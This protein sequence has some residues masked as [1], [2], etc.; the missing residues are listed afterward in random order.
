VN[1]KTLKEL[2]CVIG[3]KSDF[4]LKQFKNFILCIGGQTC[5][6]LSSVEAYDVHSKTWERISSLNNGNVKPIVA[7]HGSYLYVIGASPGYVDTMRIVERLDGTFIYNKWEQFKIDI[8]V[9]VKYNFIP[10]SIGREEILIFDKK[11]GVSCIFNTTKMQINT[12]NVVKAAELNKHNNSDWLTGIPECELFENRLWIRDN[13]LPLS[14][15]TNRPS[16][17]FA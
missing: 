5:L 10:L 15:I 2:S 4:T 11:S 12:V 3:Q 13:S 9:H 16:D 6:P 8:T 1:S 7:Q 14:L 17:N